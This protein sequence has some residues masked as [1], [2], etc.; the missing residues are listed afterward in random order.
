M[1]NA[2]IRNHPRIR[3]DI[4][5]LSPLLDRDDDVAL[6][7]FNQRWCCDLGKRLRRVG[8]REFFQ[9]LDQRFA[10]TFAADHI[11]HHLNTR[12]SDF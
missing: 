1:A 6:T 11:A 4:D 2:G 9:R 12:I 7:P 5:N 8:Q 10:I 3:D